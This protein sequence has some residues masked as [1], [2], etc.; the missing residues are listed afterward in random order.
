MALQLLSWVQP[1]GGTNGIS[2]SLQVAST[3]VDL[4]GGRGGSVHGIPTR[5]GDMC[6]YDYDC[7]CVVYIQNRSLVE[8]MFGVRCLV[9]KV[10]GVRAISYLV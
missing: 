4:M 10:L 9:Q 2:R 8:D 7:C 5:I 3:S 1:P 6:E